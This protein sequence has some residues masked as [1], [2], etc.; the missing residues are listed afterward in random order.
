M[1]MISLEFDIYVQDNHRQGLLIVM[2]KMTY[3]NECQWS[4]L[5]QLNKNI[6]H[7][8]GYV[9]VSSHARKTQIYSFL[10]SSSDSMKIRNFVHSL[11][12]NEESADPLKVSLK[13]DFLIPV[14]G[15]CYD[16]YDC[17]I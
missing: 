11:I 4:Y 9:L 3:V 6:V 10:I 16:S 5:V 17:C 15:S 8:T 2:K 7:A 1:V 13:H 14:D 12:A